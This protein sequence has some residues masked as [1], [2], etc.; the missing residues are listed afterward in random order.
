MAAKQLGPNHLITLRTMLAYGEALL[1]QRRFAPA[2]AS[3][4]AARDGLRQ[5]FP[6]ARGELDKLA[7]LHAAARQGLG[8]GDEGAHGDRWTKPAK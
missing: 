4:R 1:A 7:R 8:R 2:E 3:L 6:H 5:H